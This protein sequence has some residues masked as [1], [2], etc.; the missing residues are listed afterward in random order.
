MNKRKR[1]SR[2]SLWK[3][4]TQDIVCVESNAQCIH[5]FDLAFVH[6]PIGNNKFLCLGATLAAS[7]CVVLVN[8]ALDTMRTHGLFGQKKPNDFWFG[9]SVLA[10]MHFDEQRRRKKTNK[11][12]VSTRRLC[13]RTVFIQVTYTRPDAAAAAQSTHATTGILPKMYTFMH[14]QVEANNKAAAL[15]F[16]HQLTSL[17]LA[18]PTYFCVFMFVH[19]PNVFYVSFVRLGVPPLLTK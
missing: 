16:N 12:G 19:T 18:S 10:K 15:F 13:C 4:N 9:P 2:H 17:P 6:P 14:I 1:N 5:G 3:S 11:T 8:R 7:P